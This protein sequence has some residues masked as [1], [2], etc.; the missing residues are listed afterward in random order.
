MSRVEKMSLREIL[1]VAE[2]MIKRSDIVQIFTDIEKAVN[3]LERY[4]TSSGDLASKNK[5]ILENEQFIDKERLILVFI[6]NYREN[7]LKISN[8]LDELRKVPTEEQSN[9]MLIEMAKLRVQLT[10]QNRIANELMNIGRGIKSFLT[11]YCY[12]ES[13]KR[14]RVRIMES[15]E[16]LKGKKIED[17]KS[18]RRFDEVD[19]NFRNQNKEEAEGMEYMIQ[20]ILLTDLYEVF[21]TTDLGDSIRTM[22]LDNYALKSGAKTKDEL[23]ELR[24]L[25]NQEQYLSAVEHMDFKDILPEVKLTLREYAK[26]MDMDKL[27]LISGFRFFKALEDEKI[28]SSLYLNTK[29]ILEEILKNIFDKKIK[30]DC[31]LQMRVED[32]YEIRKVTYSTSDIEQTLSRFVGDQYI[33]TKEV[34]DYRRKVKSSEIT[35]LELPEGCAEVI[36]LENELEELAVTSEENLIYISNKLKWEKTKIINAIRNIGR[37]NIQTLQNF[38][39]DGKL[40]AQELVELYEDDIISLDTIKQVSITVNIPSIVNFATINRYYTGSKEKPEDETFSNRLNKYIEL[41]KE[42]VISEKSEE[43]LEEN[44]S[45][46]MATIIENFEGNEYDEAIKRYY[47]KGLIT[48]ESIADWSNEDLVINLYDEQIISLEDLEELAKKGKLSESH[49]VGIY[50]NA[51]W[52]SNLSQEQRVEMLSKGWISIDTI[53]NLF[54]K[55]LIDRDDLRRLVEGSIITDKKRIEIVESLGLEEA[56]ANSTISLVIDDNVK[57]IHSKERYTES[58]NYP[59]RPSSSK[60][61]IIISPNVREE[62]FETLGARK[63]KTSKIDEDNPF[64]NYQFYVITGTDGKIHLNSP[65][66]AERFYEDK[67]TE[68]TFATENATYFFQYGDLMVLSNYAKK[69]EVVGK[70]ENVVFRSN[71]TIANEKRKGNWASSVI[72]NI[73]RTLLSSDLKEYNSDNQKL[74]ILAKIREMYS[75]EQI[76]RMLSLEEEIDTGKHL[77]EVVKEKA[78]PNCDDGTR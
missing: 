75:G 14:Y 44:S 56:E 2:P 72:G 18:I 3:F 20:S 4:H 66:I 8:R 65:V 38:L 25:E 15:D 64:Y 32:K 36:F 35:L 33:S 67:E 17:K 49:L 55:N 26:Y 13:E 28:D 37:C 60:D 78:M 53:E 39:A 12:E 63:V 41:Y 1:D 62:F 31:K 30:I 51:I 27:L 5:M 22:I 45:L 47:I 76:M 23:E 69:D 46:A 29:K 57:K 6:L 10:A 52:D 42:L 59:Y 54:R 71:H 43:E 24:A 16:I 58:T 73:V 48:L 77:Y 74:I 19:N 40:G 61:K 50:E 70:K 9:A 68:R 34:E 7:I 11:Y 21:L